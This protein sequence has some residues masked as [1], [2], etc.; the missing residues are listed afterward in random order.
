MNSGCILKVL[1]I[2]G[3]GGRKFRHAKRFMAIPSPI[4]AV[5]WWRVS[6]QTMPQSSIN[7]VFIR[8][9]LLD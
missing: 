9:S 2:S 8:P 6:S 5:E 7:I 4:I 1:L 3:E